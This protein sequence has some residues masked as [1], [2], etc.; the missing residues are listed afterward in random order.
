MSKC[1]GVFCGPEL[2]DVW[3]RSSRRHTWMAASRLRFLSSGALSPRKQRKVGN[4]RT[5][6]IRYSFKIKKR[7]SRSLI[8]SEFTCSPSTIRR[9]KNK[10]KTKKQK[11]KI[12][13]FGLSDSTEFLLKIMSISVIRYFVSGSWYR[14]VIFNKIKLKGHLPCLCKTLQQNMSF[15][16]FFFK[17]YIYIAEKVHMAIIY[18]LQSEKVHNRTFFKIFLSHRWFKNIWLKLWFS[19]LTF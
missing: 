9:P 3:L 13:T 18:M 1:K 5:P 7:K 8:Y 16:S 6:T 17:I 15:Y 14:Y 10:T 2:H 11:S 4:I 19:V 12:C